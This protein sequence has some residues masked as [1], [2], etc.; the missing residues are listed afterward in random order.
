MGAYFADSR[1]VLDVRYDIERRVKRLLP[2]DPDQPETLVFRGTSDGMGT[3]SSNTIELRLEAAFDT[4]NLYLLQLDFIPDDGRDEQTILDNVK[5]AI[6]GW[7]SKLTLAQ[8][9]TGSPER[10]S[11]VIAETIAREQEL[12]ALPP[13]EEDLA[14]IREI[15]EAILKGMRQG[16]GFFTANKEGGTNIKLVADQF[17]FQDYGES[18][19]RE[20]FTSDAD[21]L[22][23]IRKFYDWP[24]R[25]D[26]L[27]HPPPELEVWKFIER[28][29]R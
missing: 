27:P 15:Q 19:A 1:P 2:R 12:A 28:E 4:H 9:A 17:V 6:D 20:E 14:A 10:L 29:L 5:R 26:W 11:Q 13:R 3:R 7:T 16:K 23:R 8:K 18:D 24:A 22:A 21:F 25:Y